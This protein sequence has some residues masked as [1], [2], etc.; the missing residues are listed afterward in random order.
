LRYVERGTG[1]EGERETERERDNERMM[2]ADGGKDDEEKQE[3]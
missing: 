3:G 1:T 2:Q